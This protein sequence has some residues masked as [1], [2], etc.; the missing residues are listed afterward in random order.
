MVV[1]RN[2][3]TASRRPADIPSSKPFGLKADRRSRRPSSEDSV[4]FG[5]GRS[6]WKGS[7]ASQRNTGALYHG[8]HHGYHTGMHDSLV[9]LRDDWR[10]RCSDDEVMF[11]SLEPPYD[12]YHLLAGGMIHFFSTRPGDG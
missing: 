8:S 7:L 2:Y 5:E 1:E 12:Q 4:S 11:Q 9:G 6:A 10:E 3:E